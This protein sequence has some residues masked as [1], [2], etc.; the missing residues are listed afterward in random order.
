MLGSAKQ[1]ADCMSSFLVDHQ[2]TPVVFLFSWHHR[3]KD[4]YAICNRISSDRPSKHWRLTKTMRPDAAKS[5]PHPRW[6]QWQESG[7]M[8]SCPM[9]GIWSKGM[10]P[11]STQYGELVLLGPMVCLHGAC[12]DM[13][14]QLVASHKWHFSRQLNPQFKWKAWAWTRPHQNK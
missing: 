3:V 14:S 9:P 5:I 8:D 10:S 1:R 11:G 4:L 6:K 7:K 2:E 12:I 13:S